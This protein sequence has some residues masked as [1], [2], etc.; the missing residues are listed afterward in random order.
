MN[1]PR[2]A[3][4][5]AQ[6][7][8]EARELE[9]DAAVG[10]AP[11]PGGGPVPGAAPGA[12]DSAPEAEVVSNPAPNIAAA[13][14]L[15]RDIPF[16]KALLPPAVIGALDDQAIAELSEAFGDLAVKYK[17]HISPAF[18]RWKEELRAAYAVGAVAWGVYQAMHA[19][20]D[21]ARAARSRDVSEAPAGDPPNPAAGKKPVEPGA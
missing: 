4:V 12:A 7:D 11:D 15:V 16:L 13:L 1:A 20:D 14:A 10:G 19:E 8:V 3:D 2:A 6:L 9:S 18:G 17:W 5:F 21:A